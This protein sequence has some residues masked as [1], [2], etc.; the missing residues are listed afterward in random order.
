VSVVHPDLVAALER[1]DAGDAAPIVRI[2]L[3]SRVKA[4]E[5]QFCACTDP[6]T[7]G[8]NLMCEACL[9]HNKDAEIRLVRQM[10][11]AHD[12]VPNTIRANPSPIR[13]RMCALCTMWDTDPRHHGVSAVGK[14]MWGDEVRP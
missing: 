12:F 10:I 8:K 4:L 9:F 7:P 2:G 1:L 6:L 5:G 3:G 13:L 14:T 11:T